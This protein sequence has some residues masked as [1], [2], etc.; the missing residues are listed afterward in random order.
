MKTIDLGSAAWTFQEPQTQAWLQAQE[1]SPQ[2]WWPAGQGGQPLYSVSVE[3]LD[4]QSKAPDF[5]H[6]LSPEF[7]AEGIRLSDNAFDLYPGERRVARVV[8]VARVARVA[9]VLREKREMRVLRTTAA[10]TGS[11][12]I[13]E[14]VLR[15]AN[16]H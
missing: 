14:W 5:V 1:S 2:L 3:L 13:P 16:P 10:S 7:A 4:A 11:D 15:S 12:Q 6:A 9:R 8:R